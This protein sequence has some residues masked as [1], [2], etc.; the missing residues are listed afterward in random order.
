MIEQVPKSGSSNLAKMIAGVFVVAA[1]LVALNPL[2]SACWH[3]THSNRLRFDGG[4]L[5]LPMLWWEADG[6]TPAS[7]VVRHANYGSTSSG[8]LE[9]FALPAEK[10][11]VD[12]QAALAWQQA[13]IQSLR[14]PERSSVVAVNVRTS[15]TTFY[16]VNNV[17]V[18]GTRLLV[19][20]A[21]GL[22]RGISFDGSDSEERQVEEIIASFQGEK[23]SGAHL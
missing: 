17:A 21:P 8:H 6:E 4:E 10:I 18:I 15:G 2:R 5:S 23:W 14:P 7:I 13:F 1:V 19:C 11:K 20:R 22:K 9:L 16:C 3:L 12:D